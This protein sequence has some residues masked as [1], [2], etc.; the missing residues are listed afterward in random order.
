M[1]YLSLDVEA[2][3][4][5]PGLYSLVSVGAVPIIRRGGAW[6]LDLDDTFYVELKPQ[7]GA[8]SLA[9]ATA[10]HGLDAS[11]LERVGKEPGVAM[12]EFRTYVESLRG[13]YSRVRP[14]AWPASFDAPYIGWIAQKYMGD[15]PLGHS[16][17]DIPSYAMGMLNCT[18][19][20]RLRHEMELAGYQKPHNENPHNA[21]SD[22]VE[23][24]ETLR[25]L[26][27][28]GE[29]RKRTLGT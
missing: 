13:R 22:A 7:L 9:E 27:T 14:A 28:L 12:S 17:F 24:A 26:L 15:N 5:F 25:W 4:P 8:E 18:D 19:R 2:S 23:Q 21:L 20:R 1:I 3:G 6:A 29:N 10:I 16:C 11:Y